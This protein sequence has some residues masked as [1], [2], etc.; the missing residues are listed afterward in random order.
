MRNSAAVIIVTYNSRKYFARQRAALEA[1][2]FRDFSLI[3]WDNGSREEERPTEADFP[4]NAVIV[5]SPANLGFAAANNRAAEKTKSEFI[6]LLNPDAFPDPLWLESLVDAAHRH[7]EAGAVGSVQIM[8]E[9]DQRFD[10]LGDCYHVSGLPWRGGYGWR[11]DSVS[12]TDGETFSACAAAA[13]YRRDCWELLKGF[14]ESYFAY[15][16]DVDIGFRLRLAGWKVRQDL[17][18]VVRHVGGGTSGKKSEFA[19]YHGTRNRIITF[20]KCMPGPLIWLLMPL[21]VAVT[22]LFLAV[23]PFR[24]SGPATW[25]GV[26]GALARLGPALQARKIVQRTRKAPVSSIAATLTWNPLRLIRRS[27]QKGIWS[28]TDVSK[29]VS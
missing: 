23:S 22:G 25:R 19:I 17:R 9:D 4:A 14:D 7:P 11:R 28:R 16:E 29:H 1:Q 27:P 8:D 5:Q 15:C 10:G 21:H 3:V 13:L 18:A 6:V 2:T 26:G 20:I 24:G 12:C